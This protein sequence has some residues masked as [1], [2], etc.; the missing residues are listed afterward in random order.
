MA[1]IRIGILGLA[2]GHVGMYCAQWAK[3]PAEQVR[4]VAA[5]DHDADR[6]AAGAKQYQLEVATSAES[7]VKAVGYRR[8]R[9]RR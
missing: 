5:W 4:L 3:L 7:L 6:A 9:N 1:S 2:H 8:S